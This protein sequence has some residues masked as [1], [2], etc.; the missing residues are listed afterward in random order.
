VFAVWQ[1]NLTTFK[2]LTGSKRLSRFKVLARIINM[3]KLPNIVSIREALTG[4]GIKRKASTSYFV[5]ATSTRHLRKNVFAGPADLSTGVVDLSPP[6]WWLTDAI[7]VLGNLLLLLAMATPPAILAFWAENERRKDGLVDWAS[8]EQLLWMSWTLPSVFMQMHLFAKLQLAIFAFI[9]IL[10]VLESIRFYGTYDFDLSLSQE[11][12]KRSQATDERMRVKKLGNTTTEDPTTWALSST[13]AGVPASATFNVMS[14]AEWPKDAVF[15]IVLPPAYDHGPGVSVGKELVPIGMDGM[16]KVVSVIEQEIV[17]LRRNAAN[18]VP[19]GRKVSFTLP[20]ALYNPNVSGDGSAGD[21]IVDLILKVTPRGHPNISPRGFAEMTRVISKQARLFVKEKAGRVYRVH[22][23]GADHDEEALLSEGFTEVGEII[24]VNSEAMIPPIWYTRREGVAKPIT[25]VS[26]TLPP[27]GG[28]WK[29]CEVR[30]GSTLGRSNQPMTICIH[31][32]Y[33]GALFSV[34]QSRSEEISIQEHTLACPTTQPGKLSKL[35]V[36]PHSWLPAQLTSATI[37]FRLN[38]ELPPGGVIDIAIPATHQIQ[39]STREDQNSAQDRQKI[40]AELETKV[41]ESLRPKSCLYRLWLCC[42]RLCHLC[43][44]GNKGAAQVPSVTHDG[45]DEEY[46]VELASATETAQHVLVKWQG[47]HKDAAPKGTDVSVT[48]PPRF[49]RNPPMSSGIINKKHPSFDVRTG[50][51]CARVEGRMLLI[52]VIDEASGIH[53]GHA[54]RKGVS[55]LLFRSLFLSTILMMAILIAGYASLVAIWF[56]LAAV[57]NPPVYLP[58]AASAFTFV[59]FSYGNIKSFRQRFTEIQEQLKSH[60]L[61]HLEEQLVENLGKL[62]EGQTLEPA[63]MVGLLTA[64]HDAD[65]QIDAMQASNLATGDATAVERFAAHLGAP[66]SVIALVVAVFKQDKNAILRGLDSFMQQV[67]VT[68]IREVN[69]LVPAIYRFLAFADDA[70]QQEAAIVEILKC[71]RRLFSADDNQSTRLGIEQALRKLEKCTLLSRKI[72]QLIN[73][74]FCWGEMLRPRK[75]F[76]GLT[77]ASAPAALR[78]LAI[79]HLKQQFEPHLRKHELEWADV[80]PVLEAIDSAEKLKDAVSDPEAFLT[81]LVQKGASAF[82][83][84]QAEVLEVRADAVSVLRLA[85]GATAYM[86]PT[87]RIKLLVSDKLASVDRPAATKPAIT[88]LEPKLAEYL[89]K[90][91]L[92]WVDVVHVLEAIDNAEELIDSD[93]EQFLLDLTKESAE[94]WTKTQGD[95]DDESLDKLTAPLPQN[96]GPATRSLGSAIRRKPSRLIRQEERQL[97]ILKKA[98]ELT[99]NKRQMAEAMRLLTKAIVGNQDQDEVF[100]ALNAIIALSAGDKGEFMSFL[101]RHSPLRPEHE[102]LLKTLASTR[103]TP[104]QVLTKAQTAVQTSAFDRLFMAMD[105]D[106]SGYID[107]TEFAQAVRAMGVDISD[108]RALQIFARCDADSSGLLN[109]REFRRAL[110]KLQKDVV[111]HLMDSMGMGR[112][113]QTAILTAS[114]G[115]MAGALVFIFLGVRGFGKGGEFAAVVNS[116]LPISSGLFLGFAQKLSWMNAEESLQNLQDK[117]EDVLKTKAAGV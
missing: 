82:F 27:G 19:I 69:H 42:Y 9:L 79:M 1:A 65:H 30:G 106:G 112:L 4:L 60:V 18:E 103:V 28:S 26:V 36:T 23:L 37:S 44:K 6:H 92:E 8:L 20:R 76:R 91:G 94:A 110:E 75:F 113:L 61:R 117:I 5:R 116:V 15:R 98:N 108:T 89:P 74:Q 31:A 3:R 25:D 22:L 10:G 47:L 62:A 64:L 50:Q 24:D 51:R 102:E 96:P 17:M 88:C 104:H 12:G 48:L 101:Q 84:I 66:S 68:R 21:A 59:S 45:V 73:E 40:Y 114:I 41:D 52:D 57:L 46:T 70:H 38:N 39:I 55:G 29:R 2:K 100:K 49:F 81:E 11:K 80:V 67:E 115:C 34:A 107:P 95:E 85:N 14:E 86:Q 72:Y 105:T 63:G 33:G 35:A 111:R 97:K 56:V 58:Y 54:R 7:Y 93:A 16:L 43:C 99:D 90:Y 109:Q 77:K 71:A 87:A 53:L 78:K 13:R 83:K 32:R